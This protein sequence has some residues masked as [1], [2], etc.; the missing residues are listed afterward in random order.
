MTPQLHPTTPCWCST[1]RVA[2]QL[3]ALSAHSTPSAQGTRTTTTSTTGALASRSWPTSTEEGTTTERGEGGWVGL[4]QGVGRGGVGWK[5]AP[6]DH[7]QG[8]R[9]WRRLYGRHVRNRPLHELLVNL[10][11]ATKPANMKSA[12][13]QLYSGFIFFSG[14]FVVWF[15]FF[16]L[17][18]SHRAG[19]GLLWGRIKAVVRDMSS[20]FVLWLIVKTKPSL[21]LVSHWRECFWDNT[22][23][24]SFTLSTWI[25]LEQKHCH[26]IKCLLWC[27]FVSDSC[28]L[29]IGCHSCSKSGGAFLLS[30]PQPHPHPHLRSSNQP[31][32]SLFSPNSQWCRWTTPAASPRRE[33]HNQG[34]LSD[35]I[36]QWIMAQKK[37]VRVVVEDNPLLYGPA[38]FDFHKH[39]LSTRWHCVRPFLY[40]RGFSNLL[41][42][43]CLSSVDSWV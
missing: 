8:P 4:W 18:F 13:T 1:M 34:R 43:A 12:A 5:D 2:V 14:E 23:S 16:F 36:T 38:Q 25:S 3:P 7:G 6:R 17:L 32:L 11:T 42:N 29:R 20:E 27:V 33:G 19:P 39:H 35:I 40:M 26:F 31:C 9:T 10:F 24:L 15:S 37:P 21:A 28:Y 41:E 22:L 30:P